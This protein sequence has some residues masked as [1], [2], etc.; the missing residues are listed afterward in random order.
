MTVTEILFLKANNNN[1]WQSQTNSDFQHILTTIHLAHGNVFVPIKNKHCRKLKARVNH[2]EMVVKRDSFPPVV[3]LLQATTYKN[4][5]KLSIKHS[6]VFP[7]SAKLVQ[8][9]FIAWYLYLTDFH[10]IYTYFYQRREYL[11]NHAQESWLHVKQCR[12]CY[13]INLYIYAHT[14]QFKIN[15]CDFSD[16]TEFYCHS[17]LG[18]PYSLHYRRQCL[19]K[20][21]YQTPKIMK[22]RERE[23]YFISFLSIKEEAKSSPCWICNDGQLFTWD[24]FIL[25]W[26][27][28]NELPNC[29]LH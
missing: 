23:Y 22:T 25:T 4:C 21:K 2:L 8:K 14:Y 29:D 15:L 5:K 10:H 13:K 19:P 6:E 9:S 27:T 1:V 16:A 28:R 11:A 7:K 26:R 20:Y 12:N 17:Q 3:Y 18:C 24:I